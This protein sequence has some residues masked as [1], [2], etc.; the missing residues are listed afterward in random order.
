MGLAEDSLQSHLI[1]QQPLQVCYMQHYH[2]PS[3]HDE[4]Q[5]T[6][7]LEGWLM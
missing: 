5:T 4:N 7:A 3:K 2:T 1:G 6:L